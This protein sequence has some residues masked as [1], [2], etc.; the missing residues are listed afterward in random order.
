MRRRNEA[1]WKPLT[2][3]EKAECEKRIDVLVNVA[4][5]MHKH[6]KGKVDLEEL[7]SDGMIGLARAVRGFDP[8]RGLKFTTYASPRIRGAMLDA[9][10]ERDWVPRLA[11]IRGE[12]I[13]DFASIAKVT[14]SGTRDCTVAGTLVAKEEVPQVDLEDLLERLTAGLDEQRRTCIKMVFVDGVSQHDTAGHLGLS[15]SRVSQLIKTAI[16]WMKECGRERLLTCE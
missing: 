15:P 3:A 9:I 11:R 6:L 13:P 1:K 12:A 14:A 8:N 16:D 5:G 4:R 2:E 7:V 10:R